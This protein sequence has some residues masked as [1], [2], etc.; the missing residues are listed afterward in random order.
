MKLTDLGKELRKIRIGRDEVLS[1]MAKKLRISSAM[2]SAVEVGS[3]TA[4]EDF[5]ARLAEQYGE[6]ADD[7]ERFAHLAE[8][9]K[10]QIKLGLESS[11]TEA[12]EAAFAFARVLPKINAEDLSKILSV[13]QKYKDSDDKEIEGRNM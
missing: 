5:V 10:K 12:K 6:V 3:K 13:L 2:L 7:V 1:D 8:L 4:P 9:T 11:S